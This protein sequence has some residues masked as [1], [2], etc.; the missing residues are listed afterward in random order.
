MST[1]TICHP[2]EFGGKIWT[3]LALSVADSRTPISLVADGKLFTKPTQLCRSRQSSALP[4]THQGRKYK[5]PCRVFPTRRGFESAHW[6]PSAPRDAPYTAVSGTLFS[7][8]AI[9]QMGVFCRILFP[10]VG[11]ATRVHAGASPGAAAGD[12]KRAVPRGPG[13]AGR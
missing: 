3:T 8:N 11:E 1:K 5:S 6:T 7:E 13:T 4:R 2:E 9:T 12:P 10:Q